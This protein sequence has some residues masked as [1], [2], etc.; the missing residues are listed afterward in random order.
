MAVLFADMP[1]GAGLHRR[2]RRALLVPPGHAQA[3]PA[4]L[5]GRRRRQRRGRRKR[6]GGRIAPPGRGGLEQPPQGSRPLAG[7]DRG[8]LSRAARLRARCH[9]PHELCGLLPDRCR[10]HQ[11]GE[12]RGHSGRTGPRLRRGLAGR[13]CADH[14]RSRSD[15]V[16]PA[17]RA[18][19]QSR[20]RVD[21]G[22]RHR[23]LPGPPRRGDRLRAAALRPRPGRADHH[24]RHAAGARRAARRRPRA[25]DALRPGRQAD[26]T[27][28]AKSG[29]AGDAG[30]RDR[31][32]TEA[33]GVSRRGSGGGA[34]LRHRPA[35]RGPDP[36]RLDPRRR[37]R[38]IGDRPLERTGAA[39]PRSEI[40]HAGDPVQHE[41]GRAGG[42][43]QI[44]LPRPEDAD[45]ARCR[46]ETV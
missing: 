10:F 4:A 29:R 9:H 30:G 44:R 16:R 18:L 28:A 36:A 17:V 41:M 2:D 42:P 23:L 45:G 34:R 33:A 5:H 22:L 27:G 20:T 15:P 3:D 40:R 6:R 31:E 13:L 8:R 1:G 14:H 12:G 43:R 11:M 24:L 35:P 32:R 38:D 37:H 19:S 39:L 26:K 46:G 25:A 7:H 21:A